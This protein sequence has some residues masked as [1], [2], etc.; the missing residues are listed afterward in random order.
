MPGGR[1]YQGTLRS[2]ARRTGAP[3]RMGLYV[4]ALLLT[5]AL[6]AFFSS[7]YFRVESVVV[8]GNLVLTSDEVVCSSGVVT[9]TSLLSLRV[10]DVQARVEML[11]YVRTARVTREFPSRVRIS[12]DERA[13]VA[14]LLVNG[15][16]LAVD[17]EGVILEVWHGAFFPNEPVITCD[18]PGDMVP[19]NQLKGQVDLEVFRM[20]GLMGEDRAF[21]SEI[22]I[23]EDQVTMYTMDGVPVFLG[24]PDALVM[25]KFL[26]LPGI[27]DDARSE[28]VTLE[29]IDLRTSR[30]VVRPKE[31][32]FPVH[33]REDPEES[34]AGIDW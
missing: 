17:R 3:R 26:L 15:T 31:G 5:L 32:S 24:V 30:P 33:P 6:C 12:I 20:L 2:S 8:S 4:V 13:P 7:A 10:R 11:P 21:L 29:Y 14:Y 18:L 25:D 23:K 16:F 22:N 27:L 19:G 28:G 9:G 34:D 1:Y